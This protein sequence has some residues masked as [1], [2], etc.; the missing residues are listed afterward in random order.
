MKALQDFGYNLGM[1]FQIV[2]DILDFVGDE[3][4]MGKP[5]GSDLRQGTI[6]LPV[7]YFMQQHPEVDVP[8]LYER[9][10]VDRLIDLVRTSEAIP[11]AQAEAEEFAQ[12]AARAL[13]AFPDGPY[14][15]ALC[16]LADYVVARRW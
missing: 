4:V 14:R 9:E 6:T 11:A 15:Q 8:A 1:A 12:K 5:V 16:T 7:F 3:G 2:D 10:G 13:D